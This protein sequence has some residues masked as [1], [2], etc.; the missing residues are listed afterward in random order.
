MNFVEDSHFALERIWPIPL[1]IKSNFASSFRQWRWLRVVNAR[2]NKTQWA[3]QK[4]ILQCDTLL[5]SA[6]FHD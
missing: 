1:K 4:F 3:K 2:T 5:I 6:Q